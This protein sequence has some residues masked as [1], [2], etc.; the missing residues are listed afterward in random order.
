MRP[1]R[2]LTFEKDY[3]SKD[4]DENTSNVNLYYRGLIEDMQGKFM[5]EINVLKIKLRDATQ[6]A[7]KI[8]MESTFVVEVKLSTNFS[9]LG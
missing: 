2:C 1:F 3:Y 8:Q 9:W 5:K 6:N 7:Q 4:Y